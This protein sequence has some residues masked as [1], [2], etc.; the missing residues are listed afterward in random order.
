MAR[1]IDADLIV[2]DHAIARSLDDGHNWNE[3][4]A[5][6]DQIDDIPTAD[7]RENVRGRWDPIN[8]TSEARQCSVCGFVFGD[9]KM[10]R[11]SPTT[12]VIQHAYNFAFC[13]M[14]GAD[15]YK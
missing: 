11:M 14:C 4:V 8:T 10:I 1:Y 13:P 6:K 5:C 3:A 2:Y 9:V 12:S 15:M 7:V